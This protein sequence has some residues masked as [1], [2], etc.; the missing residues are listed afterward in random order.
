MN[1]W[2]KTLSVVGILAVTG[3]A[4]L[5]E[6]VKKTS[7]YV[8][9]VN[10]RSQQRVQQNA[11]KP[12]AINAAKFGTEEVKK[13]CQASYENPLRAYDTYKNQAISVSGKV[14][15]I[16]PDQVG[17]SISIEIYKKFSLKYV[18]D[19]DISVSYNTTD[20]NMLK[21]LTIGETISVSG[22]IEISDSAIDNPRKCFV[23]IV[24]PEA[25]KTRK[26]LYKY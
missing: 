12:M 7:D 21:K 4:S 3:C 1:Q 23:S 13:I 15:S 25:I 20:M 17:K 11:N 14:T 2:I 10:A 5:D 8:Q 19:W 16:Y 9:D 26:I 18:D 22:I 24:D 6:A